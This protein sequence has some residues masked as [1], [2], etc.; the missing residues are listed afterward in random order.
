MFDCQYHSMQKVY[1]HTHLTEKRYIPIRID[2]VMRKD[3]DVQ[4]IDVEWFINGEF[5][6]KKQNRLKNRMLL[7]D[8][9]LP[10]L[11]WVICH[12][13]NFSNHIILKFQFCISAQRW[14]SNQHLLFSFLSLQ[15]FFF[16]CEWIIRLYRFCFG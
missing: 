8:D 4:Q 2:T 6:T 14:N 9:I 7:L 10:S 1:T 11:I 15:W 13:G 12:M 16:L 5:K 3:W